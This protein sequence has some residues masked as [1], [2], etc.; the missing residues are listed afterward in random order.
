M[1]LDTGREAI[2]LARQVWDDLGRKT[3]LRL[4][5]VIEDSLP[6]Q[7]QVSRIWGDTKGKA[8]DRDCALVLTRS[9]GVAAT[10]NSEVEWD[11]PYKDGGP[12]AA[13]RQIRMLTR[14]S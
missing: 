8:T 12:D 11:E 9:D 1:A 14:A 3:G 6:V 13:H 10:D 2:P 7:N 4:L 5:D